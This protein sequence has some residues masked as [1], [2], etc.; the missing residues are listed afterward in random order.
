MKLIKNALIYDVELPKI[1][2]IEEKLA[3]M[4]HQALAKTE[5]SRTSFT[6]PI[7]GEALAMR[8][9][10]GYAIAQRVDTKIIKSTAVNT[11]VNRLASEIEEKTG[12]K[13]NRKEREGIKEEVISDL[14][15]HAQIDA[16]ITTAFYMES[17]KKLIVNAGSHAVA[18]SFL[19]SLRSALGQLKAIPDTIPESTLVPGITQRISL[20]TDI[21]TDH[22]LLPFTTDNYFKLSREDGSVTVSTGYIEEQ[23]RSLIEDG[24]LVETA[25]LTYGDMKFRLTKDSALKQISFENAD[26]EFDDESERW[27]H[28]ASVQS[29]LV[30]DALSSLHDVFG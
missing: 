13:V 18:E 15:P 2:D 16:K 21:D 12:R 24:F 10:G 5:Y 9:A 25:A 23:V 28:C 7:H 30:I 8:I 17:K 4:P 29:S 1:S 11:E 6:S 27:A 20:C 14:L 22:H 26:D 19:S 3:Q